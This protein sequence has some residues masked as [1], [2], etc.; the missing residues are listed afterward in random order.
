MEQVIAGRLSKGTEN[1]RGL[2][3]IQYGCRRK[4]SAVSAILKVENRITELRQTSINKRGFCA[5]IIVHIAY[6]FNRAR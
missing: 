5:L 3:E 2:S 4:R 1:N 6:P